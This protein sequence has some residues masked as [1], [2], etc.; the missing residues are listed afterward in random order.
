[1]LYEQ[2]LETLHAYDKIELICKEYYELPKTPQALEAFFQKYKDI[3]ESATI[4]VL[5]PEILEDH[6]AEHNYILPGRNVAITHPPRFAPGFHHDHHFF[7][8]IYVLSGTCTQIF[9]DKTITLKQGDLC[10]MAPGVTH[11]IEVYDES[12][13]LNIMIRQSTFLDIFLNTV[14][15]KTQIS[16]FFLNNIYEK[17]KIPYLLFHTGEDLK[18]R[19]YILDMYIEQL[20]G[21]EYSDRIICSILTIFFTQLIR[22]HQKNMEIPAAQ[23]SRSKYETEVFN[24]IVNHYATVTLEGVAEHFHFSVPYCSKLIKK[25]SGQNFSNLLEN[26]RL[27]QGENFLRFTKL[28][29]AEISDRIGFKNSETFIR[30]FKRRH[31]MT[32]TQF[33]KINTEI[34]L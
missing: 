7:E 34:E 30:M 9:S 28:S 23:N 17:D 3:P 32:P 29:I 10:I 25:V 6:L 5:H 16:M 26:V 15:D 4:S 33:R 12:V 14:R 18:I 1:M 24:Y 22:L 13:I 21:D 20:E 2:I 19:N 8:M 31:N 11:A 27:Q